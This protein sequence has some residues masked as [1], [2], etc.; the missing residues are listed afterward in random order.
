VAHDRWRVDED[1]NPYWADDDEN[2]HK[3]LVEAGYDF[4]KKDGEWVPGPSWYT[5][6]KPPNESVELG[7]Q[8]KAF[9]GR[10]G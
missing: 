8:A 4:V 7:C 6:S 1:R 3:C 9:D 10:K 2:Y 5:D